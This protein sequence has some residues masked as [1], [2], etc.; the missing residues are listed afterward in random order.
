MRASSIPPSF[1]FLNGLFR[2]LTGY[3]DTSCLSRLIRPENGHISLIMAPE[4]D[5]YDPV[6]DYD[7]VMIFYKKFAE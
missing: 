4:N 1:D 7:N 2:Q 5:A 6:P 3:G